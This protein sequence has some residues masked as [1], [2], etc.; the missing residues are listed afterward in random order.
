MVLCQDC[1]KKDVIYC[2][3]CDLKDFE[4]FHNLCSDCGEKKHE[5]DCPEESK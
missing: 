4:R 5:G 2:G 3:M 1:R